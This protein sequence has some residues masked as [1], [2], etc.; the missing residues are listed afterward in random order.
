MTGKTYSLP[1]GKITNADWLQLGFDMDALAEQGGRWELVL[2]KPPRTPRQNRMIHAVFGEISDAFEEH[3]L[4]TMIE[5]PPTAEVLKEYFKARYLGK[6]TS[7]ANTK[8]LSESFDRFLR[9][10]NK[11]FANHGLP[12]ITIKNDEFKSLM[13]TYYA[14]Q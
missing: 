5:V 9:H 11:S 10:F 4:E 8:E 12:P 13:K 6:K 7:K 14:E 2:R 1:D 3:G